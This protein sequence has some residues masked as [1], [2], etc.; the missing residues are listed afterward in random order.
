VVGVLLSGAGDDGVS[1]L[2]E[3]KAAGGVVVVQ[4]PAEAKVPSMPRS[5]VIHD[6]V[7]LVL[8]LAKIASAL[9]EL[10]HGRSLASDAQ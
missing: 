9:V 10:A 5:A 4:D 3:I 6:H 7:D 1:G 2:L 8:P